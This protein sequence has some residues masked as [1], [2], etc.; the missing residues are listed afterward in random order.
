MGTSIWPLFLLIGSN[1]VYQTCS[2]CSSRDANPFA[3]LT[4]VYIIA[5][6]GSFAMFLCCGKG[7]GTIVENIR[8]MNWANYVL[9]LSIIGL[10]GGFLYLYRTGWNVSVGPICS[11][12][13]VAIGL[14]FIGFLFFNEQITWRQIVGTFLCLGGIALISFKS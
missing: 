12:T 3:I 6:L 13:G 8:A 4:V 1:L 2:K 5:A 9:G 7:G 11:Y 10:E 14:L